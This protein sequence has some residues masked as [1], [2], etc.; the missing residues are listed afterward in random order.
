[1]EKKIELTTVFY[2]FLGSNILTISE[3]HKTGWLSKLNNHL[4]TYDLQSPL[5]FRSRGPSYSSMILDLVGASTHMSA[6]KTTEL[7]IITQDFQ[8]D[9]VAHL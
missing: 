7:W 5:Q 1:M 8:F 9:T 4:Y 2:I 6:G 3:S